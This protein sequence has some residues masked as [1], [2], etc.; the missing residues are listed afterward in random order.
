M[1][2]RLPSMAR[3]WLSW[4]ILVT[5]LVLALPGSPGIA[6]SVSVQAAAAEAYPGLDSPDPNVRAEAVQAIRAARDRNAVPALI[7][8]LEDPDQRAGL[9]IAQALIEL[10]PASALPSVRRVLW[11]GEANG[12]WRAALVLGELRDT[13]ALPGLVR[14]MH[15]DEV[16]VQRTTAEALARIGTRMAINELIESLR[17]PR[18]SEI[19]AAMNGLLALGAAAIPALE[20][21]AESGNR[22]V[23]YAASTVVEAINSAAG[24]QQSG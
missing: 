7:S 16:L 2:P 8:H 5:L 20:E 11:S 13:G 6:G 21:A 12:R 19:Q 4:T 10:A 24:R 1:V 3:R 22:Q 18:P 23:E 9:Y 17:G 14:A 15:D